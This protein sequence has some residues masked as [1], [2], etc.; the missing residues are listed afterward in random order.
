MLLPNVKSL[1]IY[2]FLAVEYAWINTRRSTQTRL[3]L[4]HLLARGTRGVGAEYS[5]QRKLVE[6]FCMLQI[7]PWNEMNLTVTFP[8]QGEYLYVLWLTCVL[9][10]ASKLR[11]GP[12]AACLLPFVAHPRL[13]CRRR[14]HPSTH[15]GPTRA[16]SRHDA[17]VN[18]NSPGCASV[19]AE[20]LRQ[21]LLESPRLSCVTFLFRLV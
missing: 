21:A 9:C 4:A 2:T 15:D 13:C 20:R 1:L 12:P 5:V 6:L 17:F 14:G 16:A 3:P 8:A 7:D 10:D 19:A 11:L 18:A